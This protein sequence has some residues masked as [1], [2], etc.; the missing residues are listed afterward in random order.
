MIRIKEL[1]K[2]RNQTLKEIAAAFNTSP[3]V[4]SRYELGQ[5]EPDFVMLNKLAE[6]FGV[7]VDYLLGRTDE[8]ENV[9]KTCNSLNLSPELIDLLQQ[10]NIEQQEKVCVFIRGMLA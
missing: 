10:L 1:R 9:G 4:I 5:T 3:Q 7:S 2:A 6:Y 8:R